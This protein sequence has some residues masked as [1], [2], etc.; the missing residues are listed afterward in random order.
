MISPGALISRS[1]LSTPPCLTLMENYS[2]DSD[3]PPGYTGSV[4]ASAQPLNTFPSDLLSQIHR[5]RRAGQHPH[6]V[7][8]TLRS[9]DRAFP[10]SGC[11]GNGRI[12]QLLS[13][14]YSGP[15]Y[16]LVSVRGSSGH[17][18]GATNLESG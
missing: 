15:G 3:V 8:M 5:S 10:A 16:G 13:L 1:S 7:R 12:G 4:W 2:R 11:H 6:S 9:D 17:R 14:W 18:L